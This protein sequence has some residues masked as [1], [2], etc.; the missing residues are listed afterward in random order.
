M[1][2]TLNARRCAVTRI[3]GPELGMEKKGGTDREGEAGTPVGE[4]G[5]PEA[6]VPDGGLVLITA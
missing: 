2:P 3:I 5:V 1:L 4:E 6:A